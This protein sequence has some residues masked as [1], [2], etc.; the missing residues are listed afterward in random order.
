MSTGE[1][2]TI[3]KRAEKALRESEERFRGL[4]ENSLN[5]FA[6]HEIVTDKEGRP[7]DYV[8]LEVNPAFEELTGLKAKNIIGKR[9]TEALPGIEADPFI[10]VY[11][12][13]ALT[14]EPIHF[15]QYASPLEK[16]FE[17]AAFSP[18]KRHFAVVFS[19]ITER[20]RAAEAL[21]E[22]EE[23]FRR[24]SEATL[25]GIAISEA[26][27]ILDTNEQLAEMLGYAVD[28]LIGMD[29][30]KFVAAESRDLVMRNIASQYEVTYEH[31]AQRS[32][33]SIFPVDTRPAQAHNRGDGGPASLS[34][35]PT[36]A[37]DAT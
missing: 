32:D 37:A 23:R 15:E 34:S 24:L 36:P 26:G 27:K 16:H 31:L 25:E 8:F 13:V 11:G 6:L 33:G 12:R 19:D 3:R 20:K 9:V 35:V 7:V 2:K 29:T 30:M 10:E 4:F 21:R 14:G 22:S 18:K 17:I 1:D 5:G 28:E